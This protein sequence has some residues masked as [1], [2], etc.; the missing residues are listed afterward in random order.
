[1][2]TG[3]GTVRTTTQ[4]PDVGLLATKTTAT[5]VR[6]YHAGEP[7]GL[8]SDPL[9]VPGHRRR[10]GGHPVLKGLGH[11]LQPGQGGTQVVA[12]PCDQLAVAYIQGVPSL[13]CLDQPVVRAIQLA[14]D[15]GH[16]CRGRPGPGPVPGSAGPSQLTPHPG[17]LGVVGNDRAPGCPGVLVPA[18]ILAPLPDHRPIRQLIHRD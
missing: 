5:V 6:T 2:S 10:V 11:R 8:G 15:R 12:H 9:V 16:L 14:S 18:P 1:M 17:D 4:A 7:V 13:P 3:A